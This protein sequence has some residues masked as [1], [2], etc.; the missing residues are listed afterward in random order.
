M[1][2]P[3]SKSC[4]GP[5]RRDPALAPCCTIIF[6]GSGSL[7]EVTLRP[8]ATQ[9]F[10]CV[11]VILILLNSI[12]HMYDS[13]GMDLKTTPLTSRC[14]ATLERGKKTPFPLIG[15]NHQRLS[16]NQLKG[17]QCLC[18]NMKSLRQRGLNLLHHQ[19]RLPPGWGPSLQSNQPQAY[20]QLILLQ[21]HQEPPKNPSWD[22]ILSVFASAGAGHPK[23]CTKWRQLH[24][25]GNDQI[26]SIPE[27]R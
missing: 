9:I 2:E 20:H 14:S 22:A 10:L 26:Q 15:F 24:R 1:T 6:N 23:L 18:S 5:P 12:P 17:L 13:T 16:N 27:E 3:A 11:V 21:Q 8:A 4:P 19:L 25:R 7:P